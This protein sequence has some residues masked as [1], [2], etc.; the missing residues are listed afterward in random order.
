V[1]GPEHFKVGG[2]LA[3]YAILLASRGRSREARAT[4]RRAKDILRRH[5][6]DNLLNHTIDLSELRPESDE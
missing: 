6:Q 4:E 5:A 1:Y 2:I 3:N